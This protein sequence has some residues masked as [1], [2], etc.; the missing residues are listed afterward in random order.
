MKIFTLVISLVFM[1]P[2]SAAAE[3]T[4]QE[5][6]AAETT[7]STIRSWKELEANFHKYGHCDDG[8]IAEGYS[9]T[10]SFLMESKWPDFLTYK[11]KKPFFD[12]VK[13][14]VDET[15]EINR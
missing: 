5:A 8:A 1:L 9:E 4:K 2:L 11:M 14:H 12:F 6:I 15:W 3:C 13:K 10:V 7:S